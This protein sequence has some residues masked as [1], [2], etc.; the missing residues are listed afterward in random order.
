MPTFRTADEIANLDIVEA[1]LHPEARLRYIQ[2]RLQEEEGL[3]LSIDDRGYV[4]KLNGDFEKK[5]GF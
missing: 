2:R 3:R 5:G 4:L 1:E